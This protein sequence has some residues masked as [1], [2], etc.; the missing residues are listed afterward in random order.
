MSLT[1]R[2]H[3]SV[4]ALLFLLAVLGIAFALAS[5]H[6]LGK[7]YGAV[8]TPPGDGI[9]AVSPSAP[10]QG[11]IVQAITVSDDG[12]GLVEA[13]G[14]IWGGMLLGFGLAS[15]F[16]K[17]NQVEHWIAD[18]RR[19]ALITGALGVGG[20]VLQMK[21]GGGSFAGVLVTLIGAV[22]LAMSPTVGPAKA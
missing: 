7:A 17:R 5:L 8:P 1:D 19:L 16:L 21:L 3:R 15:A 18:G 11:P 4:L 9:A 10:S 14:P 2:Q 20:A 6:D 12:W 13:Y 22:K